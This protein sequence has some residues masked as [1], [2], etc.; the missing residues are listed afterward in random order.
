MVNLRQSRFST[1]KLPFDESKLGWSLA[2][3]PGRLGDYVELKEGG[4]VALQ[5]HTKEGSGAW[6]DDSISLSLKWLRSLPP[7]PYYAKAIQ[8]LKVALF[9]LDD[10]AVNRH[11]YGSSEEE[12]LTPPD[13][14]QLP[15][16][17]EWVEILH[18][19]QLS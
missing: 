9:V 18:S 8:A 5:L 12:R 2:T 14:G 16:E 11:G 13:R 17:K 19:L 15:S 10:R 1:D 6:V 7:D 4:E 3:T